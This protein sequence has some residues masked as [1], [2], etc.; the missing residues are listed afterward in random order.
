MS[1]GR[2]AIDTEDWK[3]RD[4]QS[5]IAAVQGFDNLDGHVVLMH[6]IYESTVETIVGAGTP[7]AVKASS[8][9]AKSLRIELFFILPR[10]LWA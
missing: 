7:A 8:A 5:V 6:S 3:S 10:F 4:A 2:A 9:A 1:P